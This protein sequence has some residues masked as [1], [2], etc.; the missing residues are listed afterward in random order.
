ML[1]PLRGTKAHVGELLAGSPT[2]LDLLGRLSRAAAATAD[3]AT[4]AGG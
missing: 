4:P 1:E 2:A 3:E